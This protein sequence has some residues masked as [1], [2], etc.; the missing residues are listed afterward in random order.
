MRD[1]AGR[2]R[3]RRGS[4]A[5]SASRTCAS[6]TARGAGGAARDRPRRPGRDDR[7]PRRPHGR[8]QVDDRQAARPLLRPGRRADH[9]R[10]RRPPRRHAG[11]RFAASSASCRRRASCSPAPCATTSPSAGPDATREDVAA[12]AQAVGAHE[13]VDGGSRTAT[14]PT[15]RSAGRGS[16]SASASSSR[17]RARCSPTRGSSSSTRPRR[18]STSAPSGGSR[19]ALRTLLADRTAFVIAHRLSTIRDADL[20]V[21]LEHG[22]CR[23]A[24]HARRADG[25]PRPLHARSTETG[26]RS[27][28]R[29]CVAAAHG[30]AADAAADASTTSM[31]G[32]RSTSTRKRSGTARR[33]LRSTRT[34]ASSRARS[35]HFEQHGFGM[36]TVE[37]AR[38]DDRRGRAP[39]PRGRARD[40]GRL[41]LPQ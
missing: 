40:R 16:R 10:R 38:R 12:A 30:A 15:S 5:T 39:A 20:I 1:Q 11:A 7:R 33:D 4:T 31:P 35:A 19:R 36:C 17:S 2:P 32:T 25:A 14:T 9:D 13:F 22:Q 8:R 34:A 6:A 21:V 29:H 18:R 26:P 28:K 23:R 37:L 41:P 27:P 24:G 3:A